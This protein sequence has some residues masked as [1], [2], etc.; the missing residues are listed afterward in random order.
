MVVGTRGYA[1]AILIDG[2]SGAIRYQHLNTKDVIVVNGGSILSRVRQ[3]TAISAGQ[4]SDEH[5]HDRYGVY[6]GAVQQSIPERA[7]EYYR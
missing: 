1:Q 5:A 3:P 6:D 7:D 2:L 4:L